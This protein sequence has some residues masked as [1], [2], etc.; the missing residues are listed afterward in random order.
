MS[1]FW[2][3]WLDKSEQEENMAKNYPYQ[4]ILLR[5]TGKYLVSYPKCYTTE[6]YLACET[7]DGVKEIVEDYWKK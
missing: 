4:A 5:D 1:H 7:D 3:A 2:N 6:H